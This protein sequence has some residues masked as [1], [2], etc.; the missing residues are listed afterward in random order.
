M[1]RT[2]GQRSASGDTPLPLNRRG[3]SDHWKRLTARSLPD[4]PAQSSVQDHICRI[5][6]PRHAM[7]ARTDVPPLRQ[8]LRHDPSA[9]R[10][11]LA[12]SPGLHG[13]ARPASAFS[14]AGE[15]PEKLSPRGVRY[16]P[17]QTMVP[18]QA[19]DVQLLHDDRIAPPRETI[20]FGEMETLPR[21]LDAK[22]HVPEMLHGFPAPVRSLIPSR[23]LTL[24]NLQY[25]FISAQ[26]PRV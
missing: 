5:L 22:M 18:H 24:R 8:R 1:M 25:L 19:L 15:D 26:I 13:D 23:N 16:R 20:G 11:L 10:A 9:L 14:R 7:A 12:C 3:F 2:R 6:V 21:P 4:G 17:R